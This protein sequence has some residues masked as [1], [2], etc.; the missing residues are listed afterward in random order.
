MAIR[1]PDGAN[2]Y[3]RIL[4]ITHWF[5]TCSGIEGLRKLDMCI[6]CNEL[7]TFVGGDGSFLVEVELWWCGR[8]CG[9]VQSL[10]SP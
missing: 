1:A 8:R 3:D 10:K 9:R 2:K 6:V 7:C 5:Y 4:I